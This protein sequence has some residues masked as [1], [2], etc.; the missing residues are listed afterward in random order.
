MN[1][2]IPARLNWMLVLPMFLL[3]LIGVLAIWSASPS[4]AGYDNIGRPLVS[5][6]LTDQIQSL[7][8][9]Y[10]FKQLLFAGI[11][12][13]V[14][15][16][17]L[18]INYYR[19]KDVSYLIYLFFLVL[20]VLVLFMGKTTHGARR[21]FALGPFAVQP[22]EFMK[23]AFVMVLARFMMH[24]DNISR[25]TDLI[26]P[27]LITFIPMFLI[28]K[29]PNL[30]T[31]LIFLPTLIV[32][33]FVAGA[34]LKHIA[35]FIIALLLVFLFGYFFVLKD[36]QKSRLRAFMDPTSAPTS[37]GFHLI[38][39]R[40]AVGSGGI[41]GRGWGAGESSATLFVPERHNDFVFTTISEEW[42]FI[43]S[44]FV[45]LL[46]LMLF[47]T[48][49]ISAYQTRE[50]FGRLLIVGL[51]TYLASQTFIN[52]GMTIGLAP[53]TGITLPFISYGGSSLLSS[54]I[55]LGLIVNVGLNQVHSFAQ[56][57]FE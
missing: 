43:G 22:S 49:L 19:L 27:L 28:L 29:Q 12:L 40:V 11:G 35:I 39:S 42:G 26:G 3:I 45:I 33:L 4:S 30:G 53:I 50:P 37:E 18:L 15:I 21:W 56:R 8:K 23:I 16:F 20:L 13:A 34:R 41:S 31:T 2:T 17:I 7:I 47:L 24:K 46:Y 54:F 32:M 5:S 10:P 36:Y 57:D 55:A 25:L 6:S 51:V 52:I 14:F 44:S 48:A 9:M 38:Q 1:E